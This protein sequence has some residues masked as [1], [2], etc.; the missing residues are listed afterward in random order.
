MLFYCVPPYAFRITIFQ[1]LLMSV[2]LSIDPTGFSVNFMLR[3]R[4]SWQQ[5]P[6]AGK[7]LTCVF[8]NLLLSDCLFITDPCAVIDF[9]A[10]GCEHIC[11]PEDGQAKC[12]CDVGYHLVNNTCN[13]GKLT[14][15]FS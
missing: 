3:V 15:S 11:V 9:S 13:S 5:A 4:N 12:F 8:L 10:P 14:L 6:Q 1:C 2:T 7:E